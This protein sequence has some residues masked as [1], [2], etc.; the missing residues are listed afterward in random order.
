VL[1]EA[2]NIERLHQAVGD[3]L[4]GFLRAV[5]ENFRLGRMWTEQRRI[6]HQWLATGRAASDL[7]VSAMPLMQWL[8]RKFIRIRS[9]TP[10][11]TGYGRRM[12]L[13]KFLGFLSGLCPG[14][15]QGRRES[16]VPIGCL[17]C[18]LDR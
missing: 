2:F 18:A 14:P 6:Q 17:S 11:P 10:K 1:L 15:A 13:D 7:L 16:V 3:P 4:D 8:R 5:P 12:K 9:N